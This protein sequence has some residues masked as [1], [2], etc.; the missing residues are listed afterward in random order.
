MEQISTGVSKSAHCTDV[1]A[2]G[3]VIPSVDLVINYDLPQDSKTHIHRVD[4][5]PRAGKSVIAIS[6]VTQYDVE[7]WLRIEVVLGKK[8]DEQ[9]LVKEE[10]MAFAERA[11]DARRTAE[12]EMKDL[13]DKRGIQELFCGIREISRESDMIWIMMKARTRFVS[14]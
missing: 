12:R 4:R 14:E 6:F 9:K 1:A 3:L 8:L 13:H 10:V 11:G 7:L 2:R 5:T